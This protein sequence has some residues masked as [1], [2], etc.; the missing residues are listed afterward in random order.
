M[1]DAIRPEVEAVTGP[2]ARVEAT[3]AGCIS[4]ALRIEAARGTFFLKASAGA[5]GDTFEAEAAGLEA[6]RAA[7]PGDLG[8]P[9][10][11]GV[12]NR[13]AGPGFLL[14]EWIE[15]GR[16]DER[17]WRR[18]GAALAALHRAPAPGGGAYGFDVDDFIGRLPQANGWMEDW[19]AFFA[20]RRLLP[21]IERARAGGRWRKRWDAHAARLLAGIG[22]LL[23][24]RPR[25]SLLHGDLWSGNQLA[26]AD[27]RAWLIDPAAYV[28]DREADLAMTELFGGFAPA[29]HDAY[30]AAWPIDPGYA[31]RRAVYDLYH[32][33]NH[34]NHFG[35]SYA[36]SVERTLALA[37]AAL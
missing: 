17:H 29:F 37:A 36:A 34:L 15:P 13:G 25:P 22:G 23:P 31:D 21:Q 20:R 9:R 8:V 12:R 26:G 4:T 19:P 14:L 18:L 10:V 27:G 33:L 24:A 35:G 2:I 32:L 6:L 5:P 28:G 30:R 3:G 16:A 1:I 7:A 11:L